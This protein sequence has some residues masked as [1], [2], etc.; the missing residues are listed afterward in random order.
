MK[1]GYELLLLTA[2]TIHL[3]GLLGGP[4]AVAQQSSTLNPAQTEIEKQRQRLGA[5]DP[6]ERRD[7]IMRLGAMHRADASRVA[8]VGLT[9]A[10][11]MI[12][13]VAAKA[14]IFVGSDES[15]VA[16][17]L[18]VTDKDE[19][20]RKEAAYALGLTKSRRATELLTQLLL[21]DKDDGV[22]SAAAVGLGD[23][24]DDSAV[25]ALANILT[26]D[27]SSKKKSKV[28][29]NVF[30][31]RAAARSL[32]QIK[33]RAG[34]PALLAVLTNEKMVEDV[35]REAAHALGVIGDPVA[36]PAL[37]NVAASS[38]DPYL[39]QAASESL[40]KINP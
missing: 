7:A 33:S 1:R 13:A 30:V 28:E 3:S 22:R 29:K 8:M 11:P 36:V 27:T 2:I 40:Q 21:N 25:V 9:D 26:Q 35:R 5:T 19:F 24:A 15:V 20:V 18:L 34:V 37:K 6:E 17:R 32:G 4:T 38:G 31:L 39:A 23:V 16:L 14:I 10:S 12:R